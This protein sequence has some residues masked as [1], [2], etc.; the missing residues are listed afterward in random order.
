MIQLIFLIIVSSSA[1]Q[2]NS[3]TSVPLSKKESLIV[4]NLKQWI[5]RFASQ[6][7]ND[8]VVI[9]NKLSVRKNNKMGHGVWTK[10]D[11][12][13]GEALA[14]IPL[15]SVITLEEGAYRHLQMKPILLVLRREFP[16]LGDLAAFTVV[17]LLESRKECGPQDSR[18]L[19]YLTAM[20]PDLKH[21]PMFWSIHKIKSNNNLLPQDQELILNLQKD[22]MLLY[23]KLIHNQDIITYCPSLLVG[24]TRV[25][26][27]EIKWII[28]TLMSNLFGV[29]REQTATRSTSKDADIFRGSAIRI[30]DNKMA[31]LQLSMIPFVDYFN[32]DSKALSHYK[33]DESR[34]VID[35]F[36]MSGVKKGEQ[37]FLQYGKELSKSLKMVNYGFEEKEDL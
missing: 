2:F 24:N 16:R 29:K 8:N 32:H 20:N 34:K 9:N 18:W 25:T 5:G 10:Q 17:L 4:S 12:Q 15:Y 28:G 13:P 31:R 36:S 19:P 27:P 14:S 30:S 22:S 3:N 7:I 37:V 11:I 23:Q 33:V 1:F 21:H 35:F 26:L 6:G